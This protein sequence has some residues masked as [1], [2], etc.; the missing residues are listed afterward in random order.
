MDSKGQA[1]S[2][3][4]LLIAAVVAGAI[5]LILLQVL[6]VLPNIGSQNPN[7]VSS[8]I[9]KSQINSPGEERIIKD[10]S[11]NNGDSLNA[12]T[13]AAG[14][15][16]LSTQQICVFASDFAPNLESF[17]DPG[18]NGKVVIYEG[19]FAQKTRLFIMCDRWND[20]IETDGSLEVYNVE[21]RFGIDEGL[22]GCEAPEPETSNYCVVAIISD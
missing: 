18:E 8:E 4:K 1:Y 13:I 6:Q 15:G 21:E 17:I 20:L 19:S 5:L 2:V 16:G 10:V 12:K 11:F 3:F 7:S 22:D 14:S 9:V